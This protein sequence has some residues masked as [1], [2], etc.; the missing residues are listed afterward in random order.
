MQT[1]Q[2]TET[3][4][5]WQFDDDVVVTGV[6]GARVFTAAHGEQLNV[7]ATL[8]PVAEIV[9]RA[10]RV[11]L[12]VSRYQGR[13]AMRITSFEPTEALPNVT[14]VFEAFEA[15]LDLPTTPAY[16]RRAWDEMTAFERSSVM[17]NASADELGLTQEQV[18]DLFLLAATIRA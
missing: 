7:P 1:F 6:D 9:P 4:R 12:I 2:D 10:P 8:I 13:E 14:N 15:S 16:Y 3:G 17:L 11:P 5:F 18:D